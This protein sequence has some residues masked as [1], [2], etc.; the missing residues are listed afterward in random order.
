[1]VNSKVED[2]RGARVLKRLNLDYTI[3]NHHVKLNGTQIFSKEE[4]TDKVRPGPND[5]LSYKIK[6]WI[7]PFP[8]SSMVYYFGNGEQLVFTETGK[9]SYMPKIEIKTN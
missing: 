3:R 9:E 2:S 5:S 1:M 6:Y 8:V 7:N 4:L